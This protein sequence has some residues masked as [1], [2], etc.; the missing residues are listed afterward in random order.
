MNKPQIGARLSGKVVKQRYAA[1][2]KS[3]H[4][5]VMLET[6]DGT[7]KLVRMGGNPFRDPELEKLVGHRIAGV[8]NVSRNQFILTD[9]TVTD[10]G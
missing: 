4:T 6:P 7:Y 10:G 1:G 3:D 9:W 5:A 8:G 2:S